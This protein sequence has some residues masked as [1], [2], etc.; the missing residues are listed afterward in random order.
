MEYYCIFCGKEL[1][2]QKRK[3]CSNSCKCK[4]FFKEHP[5][6]CNLK[7][8][9]KVNNE[10]LTCGTHCGRKRYC[11][12]I[13][14]PIRI[15]QKQYWKNIERLNAKCKICEGTIFIPHVHHIN[16]NHKDNRKENLIVLCPSCHMKIHN[17]SKKKQPRPTKK[18]EEREINLEEYRKRLSIIHT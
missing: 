3:F 1:D 18:E 7:C 2:G 11:S 5:E 9:P 6:K 17:R 15:Y 8:R 4:Q 12:N 14:K 16:G 10:C 13:C